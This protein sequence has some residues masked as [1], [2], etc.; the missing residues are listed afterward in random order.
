MKM[1]RSAE[2]QAYVQLQHQIQDALPKQHPEWIEQNGGLP[3]LRIIRVTLRRTAR[4]FPIDR[5]QVGCLVQS[6][7]YLTE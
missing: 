3:H 7:E 2:R 4:P 1:N 6:T 5:A